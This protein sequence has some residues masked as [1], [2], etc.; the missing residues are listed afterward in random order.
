MFSCASGKFCSHATRGG[1]NIIICMHALLSLELLWWHVVLPSI[2]ALK[3][4]VL[5]CLGLLTDFA[6]QD[7]LLPA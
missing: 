3:S 4:L 5:G 7:D 6:R 1:T 2:H